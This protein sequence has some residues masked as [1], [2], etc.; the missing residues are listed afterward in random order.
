MLK[1]LIFSSLISIALA[2]QIEDFYGNWAMVAHY[3]DRDNRT[4]CSQFTFERDPRNF[5][6][7]CDNE[8]KLNLVKLSGTVTV[9]NI[10]R[11]ISN[12]LPVLTVDTPDQ[13]SQGAEVSCWCGGNEYSDAMVVR[14]VNPN[15]MVISEVY[16]DPSHTELK[17]ISVA[18]FARE[19][20]TLAELNNTIEGIEEL[21][22]K[23]VISKCV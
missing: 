16:K 6:C 12:I 10:K 1:S 4:V 5:K 22:N 13:V 20:P 8:V 9:G 18:I 11:K 7:T 15:Y 3:S 17:Y 19:V 21:K 23:T 2:A 14:S